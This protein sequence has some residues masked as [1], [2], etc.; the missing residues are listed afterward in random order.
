MDPLVTSSLISAGGNLLGGILGGKEKK[1]PSI[2]EQY[3]AN[4]DHER[5]MARNRPSWIVEGAKLA[6]IHPLVAMGI[7]PSQ[8]A[9]ISIPSSG[10]GSDW[11]A[12][13]SNLGQDIGR[14]V[15]A[16]GTQEE[17]AAQKILTTQ[18]IRRGELE[19]DLLASQAAKIRSTITPPFPNNVGPHGN[20][21]INPDEVTSGLGGFEDGTPPAHQR[22]KWNRYGNKIRTMSPELSGAGLDEGPANWYYHGTRTIPDMVRADIAGWFSDLINMM[23]SRRSRK[24]FGPERR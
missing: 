8:G 13:A 22:L 21:I 1:G 12:V 11:G 14:T 6:G 15:E 10:G 18:A 19:N 4:Q 2:Y 7:Q 16:L 24:I 3:W 17:R 5:T 20:V 23:G 9:N